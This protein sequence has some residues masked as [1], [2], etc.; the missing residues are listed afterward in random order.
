LRANDRSEFIQ[1]RWKLQYLVDLGPARGARPDVG[2][3]YVYVWQTRRRLFAIQ[4]RQLP[5]QH[6]GDAEANQKVSERWAN[7]ATI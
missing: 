5:R 3:L 2:A 7:A 4:L 6:W 1:V